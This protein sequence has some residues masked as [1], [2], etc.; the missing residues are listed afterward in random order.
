MFFPVAVPPLGVL[1]AMKLSAL[2]ARQKGRDF[3]DVMFLIQRTKPDYDFLAA[4]CN[5]N[6]KEMLLERLNSVVAETD[7]NLKKRDF[8]HLLFNPRKS[9]QILLFIDV[10]EQFI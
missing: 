3:Y 10:C 9:E 1:L 6:N 2:L 8:E 5:V 7:M 4:A